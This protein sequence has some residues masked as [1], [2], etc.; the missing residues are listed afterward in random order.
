VRFLADES[1]DFAVVRALRAA[2]HDVAAVAEINPRADD[3]TVMSLARS[4]R[5]ILLTEDKD[6]GHLVHAAETATLGVLLL[7]FPSRARGRLGRTV[8]DLIA[9]RGPDLS[10]RF[11]VVTP[12]RVR[13]SPRRGV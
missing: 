13:V 2:G 5:R 3:E 1:C 4:E 10:G 9:R 11:V 7:R 8:V 6:F 12:G